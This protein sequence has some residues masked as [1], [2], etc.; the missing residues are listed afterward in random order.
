MNDYQIYET[1]DI[2]IAGYLLA[3][4][5]KYLSIE[6]RNVA[7]RTKVFFIFSS[8][9]ED[10]VHAFFNGAIIPAVNYRNS[11]ENVKNILF[12]I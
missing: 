1:A 12:D 6:R 5:E 2:W 3:S 7:N 11:I 9:V 10:K 8:D 4:G